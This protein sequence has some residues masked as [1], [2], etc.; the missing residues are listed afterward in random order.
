M[1][2]LEE[3]MAEGYAQLKV[4]GLTA[5]IK[6][7]RFQL[8]GGYMTVSELASEGQAIGTITLGGTLLFVSIDLGPMP[9][10]D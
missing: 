2:Y 6:A 7:L 4:N 1:R 10:D 3:A 9:N 5:A 8:Q